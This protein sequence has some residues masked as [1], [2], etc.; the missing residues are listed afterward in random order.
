MEKKISSLKSNSYFQSFFTDIK[1]SLLFAGG[2]F[3]FLFVSISSFAALN[4]DIVAMKTQFDKEIVEMKTQFDKEMIDMKQHCVDSLN[5][6]RKQNGREIEFLS[7][8]ITEIKS[9]SARASEKNRQDH[10]ELFK[11]I[12]GIAKGV[13]SIEG[14]IKAREQQLTK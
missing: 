5:E 1:F 4:K 9:Q 7:T 3:L 6:I 8:T 13:S 12:G 2:I 10:A 11:Q 14:Y